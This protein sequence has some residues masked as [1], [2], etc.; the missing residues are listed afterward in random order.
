MHR[1]SIARHAGQMRSAVN[2]FTPRDRPRR[3][4]L[5]YTTAVLILGMGFARRTYGREITLGNTFWILFYLL[6]N[7]IYIYFLAWADVKR[8][9]NWTNPGGSGI[10]PTRI[11]N[12]N[13]T[14]HRVGVAN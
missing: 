6:V 2:L 5:R 3:L 1:P 7:V 10:L 11:L 8:R 13:P 14:K 9:R 4:L 12:K